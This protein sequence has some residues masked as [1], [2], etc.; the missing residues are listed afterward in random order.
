M[1]SL[2][3]G[4][5][6]CLLIWCVC[7]FSECVAG[8]HSPIWRAQRTTCWWWWSAL[9][10]PSVHTQHTVPWWPF[11]LRLFHLHQ[12]EHDLALSG[13]VLRFPQRGTLDWKEPKRQTNKQ[14]SMTLKKLHRAALIRV[15]LLWYTHVGWGWAWCWHQIFSGC[16]QQLGRGLC[17]FLWRSCSHQTPQQSAGHMPQWT[18]GQ[19]HDPSPSHRS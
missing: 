12:S 2:S 14:N 9:W 18:W 5:N 11:D 1:P 10:G 6:P 19:Q 3:P 13:P 15:S 8:Q 17:S 16:S 7:A 4:V